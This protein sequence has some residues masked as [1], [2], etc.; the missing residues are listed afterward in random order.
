M[1]TTKDPSP[2]PVGDIALF[3]ND[4]PALF[5]GNYWV[6]VTHSLTAKDGSA[7]N[8][9]PLQATQEMVITAPQFTLPDAE[10]VSQHPPAGTSGLYG[11]ELPHIVFR[12]PALPW[13][14]EVTG[15]SGTTPPWLALLVLTDDELVGALDSTVR[16]STIKIADFVGTDIGAYRAALTVEDDVDTL[17]TC[18]Y[19][20]IAASTFTSLLPRIDE[21]VYLAH[22]RQANV[23]DKAAQALDP[24]GFFSTVVANRFPA[25]PAGTQPARRNIVHLVSLEGL[26]S[27]LTGSPDFGGHT[28]VA[29]LSLASWTFQCL[30][31]NAADFRG[32]VNGLVASESPGDGSM[33]PAAMWLRLPSAPLPPTTDPGVASEVSG[34]LENGFVPLAYHTRTGEDAFAWYRG[35]LTPVI[36]EPVAKSGPFLSS[37]AA[38]AY[39][40]SF[41]MFDMSLA[42][43]WQAGRA[44]ALS[45]KVFG[46][47]LLDY[48]RRTHRLTDSLLSRLQNTYFFSQSQIATLDTDTSVHDEFIS[49]LDA[50]LIARLAAAS[51]SAPAANGGAPADPP[52]PPPPDPQTAVREFLAL[53]DVQQKIA[54][55]VAD[56]LAGIAEWLARLLLLY[57]VPFNM[58]VADERLLKTESLRFF[59]VDTNWTDA[60]LDGALSLGLESSR[61]T[62][63]QMMT[64]GLLA[65][66]ARDAATRL[67]A[68]ITGVDPPAAQKDQSLISGFLLRSTLVSGW[69]TLAVR[70]YLDDGTLLRILRMDHLSSNVLL[71]LFWGVP[72]YIELSE[73]QEGF[74][75]GVDDDGN[76]TLRNLTPP[77]TSSATPIGGQIGDPL[78]IFDPHG[79]QQL[80]MRAAG[81]RTLNL[82]PS[83]SS[84][85]VNMVMGGVTKASG[86]TAPSS[87]GPAAF[88]LQ[89]VKAPEAI[90]FMSQATPPQENA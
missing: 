57:P 61:Q 32:L 15:P 45:D 85:L 72:D 30:P 54:D 87:F 3:D 86:G 29:L 33:S 63:F 88:A 73:P 38:I 65:D 42:A 70:P 77:P 23:S 10:I 24:N 48:R 14:R 8:T 89:M 9:D 2:L 28:D 51:V 7:I 78:Q 43:A 31:D 39:Q 22:C 84:G 80:G 49:V 74:R 79:Q 76:V 67:R 64:H 66:A 40:Q 50:A 37:D 69:P 58:L 5:G 12:E 47:K 1:A 18:S 83:S 17:Q 27:V 21:L 34:R 44:A 25:Q 52:P 59:Y 90:K 26:E 68:S 75:F 4:V 16:A 13:E 82:A 81:S 71:A 55:I 19:I 35:P 62:F 11:M 20:T 56:D 46:Q 53:P 36:P 6:T 41:G 60:L